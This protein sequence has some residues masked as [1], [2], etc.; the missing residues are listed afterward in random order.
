MVRTTAI[1]NQD[2]I[3]ELLTRELARTAREGG[4][5]C[6]MLAAVDAPATPNQEQQAQSELIL[7]EIAKRFTNLL[8]SYDHVGRYGSSRLLVVIPGSD[9]ASVCPVAEKLRQSVEQSSVDVGANH[10]R[11]TVSISLGDAA[12]RGEAEVLRE[13]DGLIHQAQAKGGNRV[14]LTKRLPLIPPSFAPKRRIRLSLWI[15][16]ALIAA[17]ALLCFM[18]P[19][20]LCAPFLLR[21]IL[22][23]DELPPQLPADCQPTTERPS[24]ATMQALESQRQARGLEMEGIVTCKIKPSGPKDHSIQIDQQWLDS[25][26]ING[27]L[28]DKRHVLIAATE[29]VPGGALFTVEQCLMPWYAYIRQPHDRCWEQAEFWK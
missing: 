26:Y 20:T 29:K 6:V 1:W 13:L 22:N 12:S 23:S 19:S 28:Q 25:I 27:T 4:D 7:G 21:D 2:S 10:F 16:G 14:E 5:L 17:L 3:L 24:D 11:V 15:S 18:I 9:V 8:R